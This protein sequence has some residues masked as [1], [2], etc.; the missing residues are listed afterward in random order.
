MKHAWKEDWPLLVMSAAFLLHEF[1]LLRRIEFLWGRVIQMWGLP[2]AM[3]GFSLGAGAAVLLSDRTKSG[4]RAA[5]MLLAGGVA[6]LSS[7]LGTYAWTVSHSVISATA[8]GTLFA[9]YGAFLAKEFSRPEHLPR[10]FAI[11]A[12]GTVLG[13]VAG[14]L[15]FSLAGDGQGIASS[16]LVLCA[17]AWALLLRDKNCELGPL[18]GMLA[19]G[20]VLLCAFCSVK[21]GFPA[22]YG[23]TSIFE[24]FSRGELV[25]HLETRNSAFLRSDLVLARDRQPLLF[26]HGE[27]PSGVDLHGTDRFIGPKTFFHLARKD[28]TGARVLSLGSGGGAEAQQ[29]LELGAKEVV[30]VDINPMVFA[31]GQPVYQD[32]RVRKIVSDARAF[33]ERADA[34][35][36]VICLR[37]V[38]HQTSPT[39]PLLESEGYLYTREA[40]QC[41]YDLL[42][43]DGI[44]I[45]Q[46]DS[47]TQAAPVEGPSPDVIACW[48]VVQWLDVPDVKKQMVLAYGG[49]Y[50]GNTYVTPSLLLLYR[51]PIPE[52]TSRRLEA[53][54]LRL[55][56]ASE[57][58]GDFRDPHGRSLGERTIANPPTDERPYLWPRRYPSGIFWKTALLL[59]LLC[60]ALCFVGHVPIWEGGAFFGLGVGYVSVQM[61]LLS[62]GSLFLGQSAAAF[63]VALPTFL[64][65]GG[66]GSWWGARRGGSRSMLGALITA[67][68]MAPL[69]LGAPWIAQ[70]FQLPSWLGATILLGGLGLVG[71]W[72]SVPFAARLA[73]VSGPRRFFLYAMDGL[74]ATAGAI[75]TLTLTADEGFSTV[76]AVVGGLYLVLSAAFFLQAKRR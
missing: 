29:F 68:L 42:T 26:S 57:H 59:G 1:L 76:Y 31:F 43:K 47:S 72:L 30:A 66:W 7:L 39:G 48:Y 53:G 5:L 46:T 40:F 73:L 52:E 58:E 28:W 27:Y 75:L 8:L 22:R 20:A 9:I 45:I 74:G 17:L 70:L 13:A 23:H 54:G 6:V 36:D 24:N 32:R 38:F 35:F 50:E 65:F 61:V 4:W 12:A 15:L 2:V 33:A 55:W 44:L 16:S 41:Y 69:A 71:F 49:G 62:Q 67:V 11:S 25:R 3:I 37:R 63:Q 60:L 64:C 14:P 34:E 18:G 56:H 21:G 10:A 51:S 19:V